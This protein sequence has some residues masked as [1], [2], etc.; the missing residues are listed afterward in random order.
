MYVDGFVIP[1]K[2]ANL[3]NYKKM[4]KW[5]CKYWMKNG[6]VS[7]FEC[8][9]DDLAVKFGMTFTKLCKLKSDETVIFSFIIFKSKTHRN[10]VNKKVMSEPS[11]KKFASMKMPF[12]MKR[13]AF[14]G[15]KSIIIS[16]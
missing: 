10:Q 4:A 11:M 5:G 6:A 9:G 13:F 2:K 8:V 3:K 12:D 16:K 14:G 15:F 1:I 7:Y